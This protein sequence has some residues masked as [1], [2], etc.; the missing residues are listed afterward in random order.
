MQ[1]VLEKSRRLDHFR[2]IYID[3]VLQQQNILESEKKQ[4][5]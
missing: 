3:N 5:Q 4:Y 1:I 2:Y